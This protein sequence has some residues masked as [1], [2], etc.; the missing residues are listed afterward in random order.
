[1]HGAAF[2]I[3]LA[4]VGCCGRF[5]LRYGIAVASAFADSQTATATA[6]KRGGGVEVV[7]A[8]QRSCLCCHQRC[9]H[10]CNNHDRTG[11]STA[12]MIIMALALALLALLQ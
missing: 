2:L 1:M 11:T 3:V 4:I 6:F 7:I 9:R 5:A 8:Q 12:A 10:C